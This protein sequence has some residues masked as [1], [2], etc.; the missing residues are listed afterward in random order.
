M[1]MSGDDVIAYLRAYGPTKRAHFPEPPHPSV[2]HRLVAQRRA[3]RPYPG[4]YALPGQTADG[5]HA[6]A[7]AVEMIDTLEAHGPMSIGDL[8]RLVGRSSS[9]VSTAAGI[10]AARFERS[11]APGDKRTTI[12]L[13]EPPAERAP[14]TADAP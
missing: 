8:A 11:R 12:S 2:L 6:S 1:P 14:T 4:V 7:L 9:S 5:T 10:Y 3:H 13:R